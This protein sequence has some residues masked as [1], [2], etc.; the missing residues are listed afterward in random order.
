MIVVLVLSSSMLMACGTSPAGSQEE[1]ALENS[2][3]L[4]VAQGELW[5]RFA[6]LKAIA[7]E[8]PA[9]REVFV[10]LSSA[11]NILAEAIQSNAQITINDS[12]EIQEAFEQL[13]SDLS[14]LS[15][16][17]IME[18]QQKL[19]SPKTVFVAS[20]SEYLEQ[21]LA[22]ADLKDG[23]ESIFNIY[24]SSMSRNSDDLE[25]VIESAQGAVNSLERLE[26]YPVSS[27]KTVISENKST[28]TE[29]QL[30]LLLSAIVFIDMSVD[31]QIE[32]MESFVHDTFEHI[33][34]TEKIDGAYYLM[35]NAHSELKELERILGVV[36]DEE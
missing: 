16:L 6:Q 23:S 3:E 1:A 29:E 7:E 10:A 8:G 9:S 34:L 17:E 30:D 31:L 28:F 15:N 22:R 5:D 4:E 13:E 14:G 18:A 35:A 36:D 26:D 32:I 24:F 20:L 21:Y 33:D 12:N 19:H 2:E 25:S 11:V 27:I